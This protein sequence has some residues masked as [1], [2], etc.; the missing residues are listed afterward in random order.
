[1]DE[2]QSQ[3]TQPHGQ[4]LRGAGR[5]QR[6]ATNGSQSQTGWCTTQG[7][8]RV[9][10]LLSHMMTAVPFTALFSLLVLAAVQGEAGASSLDQREGM[11]EMLLSLTNRR[12][13]P[14]GEGGAGTPVVINV[15][16]T[17]THVVEMDADRGR[18][19]TMGYLAMIWTDPQMR[20]AWRMPGLNL[21]SI[22]LDADSVWTPDIELYNTDTPSMKNL[23]RRDQVLMEPT[24]RI[25]WVPQLIFTSFCDPISGGDHSPKAA[26]NCTLKF[27][28]W[29]YP[30]SALDLLVA[31]TVDMSEF[32][33]NP[34]W[35]VE[36]PTSRRVSRRFSC[37]P[38][39][40]V[41]AEFSFRLIQQ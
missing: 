19:K 30:E 11:V 31:D 15:T 34:R 27:G 16:F 22:H 3:D 7:G 39:S 25:M 37:C 35:R 5:E 8:K 29:V 23:N 28:S 1:M 9:R 38:D 4:R 10:L 41:T 24:D 12:V 40:Y 17:F 21:T 18:L 6:R 32:F 13:R 20:H 2:E 36:S 14:D 33:P 26:F